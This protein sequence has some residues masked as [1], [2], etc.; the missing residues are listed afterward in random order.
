M[1]QNHFFDKLNDGREM[2]RDMKKIKN[3]WRVSWLLKG[4]LCLHS[5]KARSVRSKQNFNLIVLMRVMLYV[6]SKSCETSVL[7]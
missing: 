6:R 4:Q 3:T 2:K 1:S 7:S 5:L